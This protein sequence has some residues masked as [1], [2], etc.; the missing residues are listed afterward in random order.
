MEHHSTALTLI[1]PGGVVESTPPLDISRDTSLL[2]FF[3]AHRASATFFF[4]VLRNFWRYIRK[5]R[6]YLIQ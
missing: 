2:K 4:R 3:P 6:A 5:N 1:R